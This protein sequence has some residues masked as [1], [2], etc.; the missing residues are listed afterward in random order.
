MRISRTTTFFNH[1]GICYRGPGGGMSP[2]DRKIALLNNRLSAPGK[3][4]ERE[5]CGIYRDIGTLLSREPFDRRAVIR[6]C[7]VMDNIYNAIGSAEIRKSSIV[8]SDKL[9]DI[10]RKADDDYCIGLVCSSKARYV[11][12]EDKRELLLESFEK[13]GMVGHYAGASFAMQ[14]LARVSEGREMVECWITAAEMNETAGMRK[15]AMYCLDKAAR[16]CDEDREK[17]LLLAKARVFEQLGVWNLATVKYERAA[18][19][20]EDEERKNILLKV[21]ENARK[22]DYKISLAY[23]LSRV[24]KYMEKDEAIACLEE[25]IKLF[26]DL[27]RDDPLVYCYDQLLKYKK[28]PRER[29]NIFLAKIEILIR[30]DK[31]EAVFSCYRAVANLAKGLGDREAVGKYRALADEYRERGED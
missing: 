2:M 4:K 19:L 16:L 15:E 26:K 23:A 17:R 27:G 7:P 5:I 21:V 30:L 18:L 3:M 8:L 24:E 25:A 14:Q 11:D 13:L 29:I 6:L 20:T 10:S 22:C 28:D 1:P 12:G 9:L 31:K